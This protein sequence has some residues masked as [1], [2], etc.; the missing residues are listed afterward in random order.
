MGYVIHMS[1]F[2]I[3][4]RELMMIMWD[5]LWDDPQEWYKVPDITSHKARTLRALERKGWIRVLHRT[6]TGCPCVI[7]PRYP[8]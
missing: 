6:D 3:K 1:N 8:K 2:T 5:I 4:Q 7:R